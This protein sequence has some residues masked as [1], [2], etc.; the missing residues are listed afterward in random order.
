[1][2]NNRGDHQPSLFARTSK[3]RP[4]APS[5]DVKIFISWSGNAGHHVAY[6]LKRVAADD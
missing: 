5:A 4:T 1:M 3:Q 2:K 6:R